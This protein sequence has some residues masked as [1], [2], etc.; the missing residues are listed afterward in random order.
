[1]GSI[2]PVI[3][4]TEPLEQVDMVP[5]AVFGRP[6]QY[7]TLNYHESHDD[8][9]VFTYAAFA[10]NNDCH[11]CLR[12]Y[13]GHPRQTVSLYLEYDFANANRIPSA[14][15]FIV[16][17]FH[18]PSKAVQWRRG[19]HF[20]FGE[21]RPIT[22]RLN[23]AEARILALKI[24]LTRPNGEAST[25]YI[26]EH[27]PEFIPLTAEDLE[28]SP[29]RKNECKWQQVVGNV[30]S[31][32]D[33]TTSIFNLGYADRTEDGIRVTKLGRTYLEDMGFVARD[34]EEQLKH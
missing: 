26:K 25:A 31:H 14:I 10:I 21:V 16:S 22:G 2:S 33:Q 29:T 24:A 13:R 20:Q 18:M 7:F 4:A 27:V 6:I 19:E 23:E 9:D 32:K 15:Q 3:H 11:F 5:H 17:G 8:L 28:P 12:H 30:I 1:M 34:F